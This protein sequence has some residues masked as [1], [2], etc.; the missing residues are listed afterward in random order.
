MMT[1]EQE[2]IIE[3]LDQYTAEDLAKKILD[4]VFLN[5]DDLNDCCDGDL[6]AT[7]RIEI[8]NLLATI[9]SVEFGKLSPGSPLQ[10][11]Q[12]FLNR[13]PDSFHYD[14][15]LKWKH[16]QEE[17]VSQRDPADLQHP[18]PVNAL[19]LWHDLL[20]S[21]PSRRQVE[22]FVRL[23]PDCEEAKEWLK[24]QEVI[25][26]HGGEKD[27]FKHEYLRL[28][29]S[30]AQLSDFLQF[31]SEFL[32]ES[33]SR[34]QLLLDILAEDHNFFSSAII[35]SLKQKGV[36]VNTDL[37]SAGIAQHFL[38]FLSKDV[39]AQQLPDVSDTEPIPG[40]CTELYFW[41]IPSS[42]KTCAIGGI[43]S[44]ANKS[45]P[46]LNDK[47]YV[48]LEPVVGLS[49]K[50]NATSFGY[51]TLLS[52]IFN[53]QKICVLPEGT[54]S[55]TTAFMRFNLWE[56]PLDG[57]KPT[58]YHPVACVDIA[59]EI[60]ECMYLK[61]AGMVLSPEQ[62]NTLNLV[63]GMLKNNHTSNRK[64]HF[65]VIEYG[66]E[67][68]LHKG[69]RQAALLQSAVTYIAQ[70]KVFDPKYGSTDCIYVLVTKSDKNPAY[71]T[72]E[73]VPS[74]LQYLD[75]NYS[76][77][78]KG[79][80]NICMRNEI[81]AGNI[82]VIPY[83]LGDVCFQ[84]FCRFDDTASQKVIRKIIDWAFMEK[85]GFWDRVFNGLRK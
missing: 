6:P 75:E 11:L 32:A 33:A 36:F 8:R 64:I 20:R 34:K 46:R 40:N 78:M 15:V 82:P 83:T 2:Q 44:T 63:T 61:M 50:N 26:A 4:G 14:T 13:F 85:R 45:N 65:F 18:R 49:D 59:G 76:G 51:M 22:D 7:K 12:T 52:E 54:P 71:G 77:F 5:L 17:Q 60:F 74:L 56:N 70:H 1:T 53:N 29:E 24:K 68:L 38:D 81:N 66:A 35:K 57:K 48:T 25:D 27:W 62:E 10:A 69:V 3:N 23:N 43:L 58:V 42:G 47:T 79:L 39:F 84:D 31:I 41:G 28:S 55:T 67:N 37:E 30:H 72:P 9:D 16:T 21:K 73:M 19:A 80:K